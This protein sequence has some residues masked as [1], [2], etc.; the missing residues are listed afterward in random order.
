MR[1]HEL[2]EPQNADLRRWAAGLPAQRIGVAGDWKTSDLLRGKPAACDKPVMVMLDPYKLVSDN[3]ERAG[4]AGYLCGGDIRRLIGQDML[5]LCPG[6][7][8]ASAPAAL[9]IMSYSMDDLD[10][11]D[12]AIDEC[13]GLSTGWHVQC[14]ATAPLPDVGRKKTSCLLGNNIQEEFQSSP[15]TSVG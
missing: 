2:A 12:G 1:L 3:H 4:A 14:V 13:F 7:R 6:N 11:A 5:N 8:T 10:L 9:V 15:A